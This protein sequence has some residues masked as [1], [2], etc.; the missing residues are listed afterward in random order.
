MIK[1]LNY[2]LLGILLS[3]APQ[4]INAQAPLIRDFIGVNVKPHFPYERMKKVGYARVFHLW[5]D[6]QGVGN[7]GGQTACPLPV[8]S[9]SGV[10]KI[11]WNPSY[12]GNRYVRYDDFYKV[13]PQKTIAVLHGSAPIMYG[14]TGNPGVIIG[15]L[16]VNESTSELYI[17]VRLTFP[18]AQGVK[19][20]VATAADPGSA[21]QG[22]DYSLPATDFSIPAGQREGSFSIT[23]TND[24]ITEGLET[25]HFQ[26]SVVM[27]DVNMPKSDLYVFLVDDDSAG[28]QAK[29]YVSAG[30]GN[31]GSGIYPKVYLTTPVQQDVVVTLSATGGSAINTQFVTSDCQVG[32]PW[33]DLKDYYFCQPSRQ[34]TIPA[35]QTSIDLP[36]LAYDDVL[37]EPSEYFYLDIQSVSGGNAGFLSSNN[38]SI[39]WISANGPELFG[40]PICNFYSSAND[41]ANPDNWE[42]M[43][44][45]ASFF[46]ARYGAAPSG[47]FPSG[48]QQLAADNIVYPDNI[49]LGKGLVKYIEVLNETDGAWHDSDKINTSVTGANME[50]D[51]DYLTRYYFRPDQYAAMLSAAYDGNKGTGVY[52]N[53]NWGIKKLSSNTQV[54]LAGTSDMRY[55]YL[56]FLRK[57]W[58]AMR[59]P[60]DYPFDIVNYHFYSTGSHPSTTGWDNFY[61]GRAFF[62]GNKGAFPESN[63]IE[64]KKRIKKLLD[65]RESNSYFP[66]YS[67]LFPDKP[68]WITEFGYDTGS[69]AIGVE[70]TCGFDIETVQ[71]QWITR[72]ILEASAA[73]S[74]GGRMVQKV[75]L[76]ELNDDRNLGEGLFANS[77]LLSPEG[78]PKASW[79]HLRTLKSVLDPTHFL[80]NNEDYQVAFHN[81]AS[82]AVMDFDTPRMY[83]YSGGNDS[84]P[85]IA[86]WVPNGNPLDCGPDK[87]EYHGGVLLRKAGI[88]EPKP[89]VQVIEV[90]NYDEDGRRTKVDPSLIDEVTLTPPGQNPTNFWRIN[91]IRPGDNE[92]VLTETPVYLR[93]NQP[94]SESDREVPPVNNLGVACL[95]CNTARLTWEIPSH[96]GYSFYA[97]YYQIVDCNTLNP[98]FDPTHAT[99][100]VDKLPG[101]R[102]DAV[103]PGLT[104]NPGTCY[105]FWVLPFASNFNA[106]PVMPYS[107]STVDL[108]APQSGHHYVIWQPQSCNPCPIPFQ[109]SQIAI[110]SSPWQPDSDRDKQFYQGL[111]DPPPGLNTICTELASSPPPLYE[112][113]PTYKDMGIH[114]WNNETLQFV[115]DFDGPKYIDA[116]YFFL[117][118]GNGRITIEYERDC[119]RQWIKLAPI[120][121]ND[122]L[123]GSFYYYWNRIVNTLFNKERIEKIR[124]TIVGQP[125]TGI[126]IKRFYLCTRDATDE[127]PGDLPQYWHPREETFTAATD[128]E[129]R[130]VDTHSAILSWNGARR[131][132]DHEETFPVSAYTIQY[133]IAVEQSGA[134]SHPESLEYRGSEWGGDNEFALTDLFP[135]TTYFVD[136]IPS[137]AE[138]PCAEQIPLPSARISFTTSEI[139]SKEREASNASEKVD[140]QVFPV[141]ANNEIR[142]K[143]KAD[144]YELYR[145]HHVNGAV[146]Q[147]GNMPSGTDEIR[148]SVKDLPEGVYVLSLIGARTGVASKAFLIQH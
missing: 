63:N 136:I 33:L 95:G 94:Y 119:C 135:S 147:E 23:L 134:L 130:S 9:N 92:F 100:L 59:G 57:A 37:Q 48:F 132:L 4:I 141:P 98:V 32:G 129:T 8:P 97:I 76:Y 80:K 13:L 73:K 24:Q 91:G 39:Q 127:C 54:L 61:H 89:I 55:D 99:L 124:V 17:P 50:T 133:S 25:I 44:I 106:L 69:S 3:L 101:G 74:S 34:V 68:T 36:I 75:F 102:T 125:E 111:L 21:I 28:N 86:A 20:H 6:D 87:S 121:L 51:P 113:D 118:T 144:S 58:D 19:F 35:G 40:K 107:Y 145:I 105:I 140:I 120:D 38:H 84:R 47:G 148:I 108:S 43:A 22:V 1:H 104:I 10:P 18:T 110:I 7:G 71:G 67:S 146:I 103:V 72:Y 64:L 115:I 142:V 131:Y 41:H 112:N 138:Y 65:D 16:A 96:Q 137:I 52:Q 116:L 27:G 85:T 90:V 60:G 93:V 5:S 53:T 45:R 14:N 42:S 78:A 114:V 30:S 79:Y 109:K 56:H 12:N 31:E 2:F 139:P 88:N 29:V 143:T 126:N 128:L 26:I 123:S 82:N 49:G 83:L 15:D 77:G 117:A 81:F 122:G 46:A 70:P 62:G 66:G 11:R